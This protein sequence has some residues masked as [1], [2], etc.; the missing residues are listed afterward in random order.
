MQMLNLPSAIGRLCLISLVI[1]MLEWRAGAQCIQSSVIAQYQSSQITVQKCGFSPFSGGGNDRY[2]T[3]KMQEFAYGQGYSAGGA[4]GVSTPKA[5]N[6]GYVSFSSGYVWGFMPL[7]GGAVAVKYRHGA[8]VDG[9]NYNGEPDEDSG[10]YSE[11]TEGLNLSI[12]NTASIYDE[13]DLWGYDPHAYLTNCVISF[14]PDD[15]TEKYGVLELY[16]DTQCRLRTNVIYPLVETPVGVFDLGTNSVSGPTS[17]AISQGPGWTPAARTET[18]SGLVTTASMVSQGLGEM[19]P[20]GGWSTGAVYE[21]SGCTN[22]LGATPSAFFDIAGDESSVTLRKL[23]YRFAY[24]L[25]LGVRRLLEWDEVFTPEGGGTPTVVTKTNVVVGTGALAYTPEFEILPPGEQ[26]MTTVVLSPCNRT[27]SSRCVFGG[28]SYTSPNT[29]FGG[30]GFN[31]ASSGGGGGAAQMQFG[32]GQSGPTALGSAGGPY[33]AIN[34]GKLADGSS[35]GTLLIQA[36]IPSASLATPT[37]LQVV[38]ANGVDVIYDV[39][40]LRQVQAPDGLVDVTTNGASGY[41]FSLYHNFGTKNATSGMWEG[42]SDTLATWTVSNGGDTNTL[43]ITTPN[44]A[45][46]YLWVTNGWQVTGPGAERVEVMTWNSVGTEQTFVI[47][48]TSGITLYQVVN[49]YTTNLLNGA[50]MLLQRVV[51]QSPDTQTNVWLYYGNTNDINYGALFMEIEPGGFWRRY[52]YDTNGRTTKTVSQFQNAATNANENVLRVREFSYNAVHT[53][54]VG[55]NAPNLART[56]IDRLYGAEVGRSYTILFTNERWVVQ[57]L[58]TNAPWWHA[59]NL[60]T[61]SKAI[62]LTNG[63]LATTRLPNG[64]LSVSKTVTNTAGWSTNV[65]YVGEPAAGQTN[66]V[67]GSIVTTIS[68][69]TN[70]TISSVTVAFPQ[71]IVTESLTYT[72]FD[73]FGRPKR[74][75]YADGSFTDTVYSD[76]CGFGSSTDR[77][78]TTTTNV[79]DAMNRLVTTTR[80]GVTISNVYD[81]V[82][83]LVRIIRHGGGAVTNK[84]YGYDTASRLIGTTN[85]A[86]E[87]AVTVYSR[88]GGFNITTVTTADS[89]THVQKYFQDGEL[90]ELSGTAT[91]PFRRNFYG[92]GYM[93]GVLGTAFTEV[94]LTNGLESAEFLIT[95][96]DMAGRVAMERSG[97]TGSPS[98]IYDYNSLGQLRRTVDPDGVSMLYQYNGLGEQEYEVLDLNRN[99]IVDLTSDRVV[100]HVHTVTN[101]IHGDCIVDITYVWPLDGMNTSVESSRSEVS[102][103]GLRR[104]STEF[105]KTNT[106]MHFWAG[107]GIHVITNMSPDGAFTVITNQFGQLV[108]ETEYD[109]NGFQLG[110][111]LYGYDGH[112]RNRWK[113]DAR[114]GTTTNEFDNADRVIAIA[115]PAA[116]AIEASQVTSNLYDSVGRIWKTVYPDGTAATN[117]YFLTGRLKKTYGSRTY[118]REYWYDEQGRMTRLRTW[119]GYSSGDGSAD[120]AW[121]YDGASGWL[122][123][124]SY[125]G[126]P[127]P[128]FRYTAAGRLYQRV[129]ARGIA[130]TYNTNSAGDIA[131]IDY[132]DDT[133]DVSYTYDRLGRRIQVTDGG[134]T[135][136]LNYEAAGTLQSETNTAGAMAGLAITNCYDPLLRRIAMGLQSAA[137]TITRYGYD[138]ASRMNLVSNALTSAA[139]SYAVNSPLVQQIEFKENGTTRM[140]INKT[141][142]YLNRLKLITNG[143]TAGGTENLSFAYAYN[144]ANQRVAVT[145][146]DGSFSTYGYD[147]LGQLTLAKK[148]WADSTIV[149]GQQFSVSFDDI[150]NRRSFASG[151][152]DSG[153]Q[154]RMQDY[155]ANLL[156]QYTQ[157]TVPGYLEIAG[158]ATN[159]ATITVNHGVATRKANY[160]RREVPVANN[161]SPLWQSITNNAVIALATNDLNTNA[162]GT[163]FVSKNPETFDYDG[164][165]NM[166]SDGRWTFTWDAENRLVRF[167]SRAGA[168]LGSSN[169]VSFLYDDSGR[170]I[171]K[172]VEVFSGGAW[173]IALSN[174]FVYDGWN[175]VAELNATNRSV[176]NAFVWGLDLTGR[177]QEGGGVG[178]LLGFTGE[179]SGTHFPGYDANG[180]VVMLASASN[181]AVTAVYDYT[182][183]GGI[184]RLTGSAA[185]SN[186]YRFSTKYYD[187]EGEFYNY[188]HRYYNSTIGRWISR[189]PIGEHD[190]ACLYAHVQNDA[191][192]K[193]DLLGL[194]TLGAGGTLWVYENCT[195]CPDLL[196]GFTYIDEDDKTATLTPVPLQPSG[197]WMFPVY[198]NID[199][200]YLPVGL[201][202]KIND[203]GTSGISCNCRCRTVSVA[204]TGQSLWRTPEPNPPPGVNWPGRNPPYFRAPGMNVLY[205]N[206]QIVYN[207]YE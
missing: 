107:N 68:T 113:T 11:T 35:A 106:T 97:G 129:W 34:L 99:G 43:V 142:D 177:M 74:T 59:T 10:S 78:G 119:Q 118:P 160:Y 91:F 164:D 183:F 166:I 172:V 85:G 156:N 1:A 57:C 96:K 167:E 207:A 37:S 44:G 89:G 93:N 140:T 42:F 203:L 192:N 69:P 22:I 29:T 56:V 114:N 153:A 88:S 58:L 36:T 30:G 197:R 66:I 165:G 184:I 159:S 79:F 33:L 168:P 181:G 39:N 14:E 70:T 40:G 77:D 179:S 130:T 100:R 162:V 5:A 202:Y 121:Q 126:N 188:G 196:A 204:V 13:S 150:G 145:N 21:I 49:T 180:N 17:R 95:Y 173:T 103:D 111:T 109:S 174:R 86:G 9:A 101:D 169:R 92:A 125:A 157:R 137:G 84:M 116:S 60:I 50:R 127:G 110:R 104:F 7:F 108:T 143:A 146:S 6:D 134:G 46:T 41:T 28:N 185:R 123:N 18:L 175:I 51:G 31:G 187:T 131:S 115:T 48:N 83:R 120:T 124:K 15:S 98:K 128:V 200:L 155:T 133:P 205:V 206:G 75:L 163:V 182:P 80:A 87:W 161:L 8:A 186:P 38:G 73:S 12:S 198:I 62:A 25:P 81:A 136:T 67:K 90:Y 135:R 63:M 171:G 47:K 147:A 54:D 138:N 71:N 32:G 55:T 16:Y 194:R 112:R 170:R 122:T 178:G 189:D 76:C 2:R 23:K 158:S 139:Y 27:L 105:G 144:N 141:F 3:N 117:E 201:A 61:V 4:G 53:N 20:Y 82:G 199:A 102:T 24:T 94:K 19:C 154:L 52:E 26:G 149:A 193:W 148:Y 64:V 65:A 191:V 152:S 195:E 45:W 190:N 151:G 72:N 176:I 132:S